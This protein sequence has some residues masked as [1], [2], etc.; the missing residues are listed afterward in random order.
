MGRRPRRP[1][2]Y[3]RKVTARKSAGGRA[4]GRRSKTPPA[5]PRARMAASPMPS[6]STPISCRKGG[7]EP[8][9]HASGIY[10]RVS[11]GSQ[12]PHDAID[13]VE[14]ADRT[15][16]RRLGQAAKETQDAAYLFHDCYCRDGDT[17][18]APALARLGGAAQ[19]G[20]HQ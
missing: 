4:A 13:R 8:K 5:T 19:F 14:N 20:E 15:E 2:P 17:R 18:R 7:T 12:P 1:V 11:P 3:L 6:R 10:F 9:R 16:A